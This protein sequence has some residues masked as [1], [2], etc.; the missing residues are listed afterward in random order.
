MAIVVDENVAAVMADMVVV[1]Y[2]LDWNVANAERY[3]STIFIKIP[4]RMY[5]RKV[6]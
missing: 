6:N 1:D 4:G 2:K 5:Y 3:S